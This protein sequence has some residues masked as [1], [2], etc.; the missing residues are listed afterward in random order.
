MKEFDYKCLKYTYDFLREHLR[1]DFV[2][3]Q[4]N[5]KDLTPNEVKQ[6]LKEHE[7]KHKSSTT[8]R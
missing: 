7:H 1:G 8:A 3:H 6:I 4:N 2:I 5:K